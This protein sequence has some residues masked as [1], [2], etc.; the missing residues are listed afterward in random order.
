MKHWVVANHCNYDGID[1]HGPFD[2]GEAAVQFA[3]KNGGKA[4]RV[5]Q[6]GAFTLDRKFVAIEACLLGGITVYGWFPTRQAAE[7]WCH[8]Q[9]LMSHP[10]VQ[11][12]A[13]AVS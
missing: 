11:F 2:T 12:A 10:G 9:S 3:E 13:A 4:R 6:S 7:A 5:V 8:R 1:I